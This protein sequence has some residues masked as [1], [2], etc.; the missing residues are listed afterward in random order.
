MPKHHCYVKQQTQTHQNLRT[1]THLGPVFVEDRARWF[2]VPLPPIKFNWLQERGSFGVNCRG[3]LEQRTP[4]RCE[5]LS[6]A[7]LTV[8][9]H[10][11]I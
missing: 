6:R 8:S 1:I 9:T 3:A 5:H 4:I 10:T 7:T 2:V 11:H